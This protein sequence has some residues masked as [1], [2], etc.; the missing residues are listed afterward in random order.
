VPVCGLVHSCNT[1]ALMHACYR[2]SRLGVSHPLMCAC[3]SVLQQELAS[4]GLL[5]TPDSPSPAR[6]EWQTLGKL[7]YLQACIREG[8][9]LFS[10]AA[11]GSWR[12]SAHTDIQISHNLTLPKASA[13]MDASLSLRCML[14]CVLCMWVAFL[15]GRKGQGCLHVWPI[16]SGEH[17]L[18]LISL[19]VEGVLSPY[20]GA[21]V[22]R[23]EWSGGWQVKY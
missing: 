20:Q 5:A 18:L 19:T 1:W 2:G 15:L 22:H 13:T 6:F 14:V 4:A 16:A 11:N 8:L 10:P 7:S 21:G 3:G 9:R 17:V 12:M 23:W